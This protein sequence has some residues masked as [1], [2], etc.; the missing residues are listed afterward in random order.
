MTRSLIFASSHVGPCSFVLRC[1]THGDRLPDESSRLRHERKMAEK[2][3]RC[4]FARICEAG[5]V[6]IAEVTG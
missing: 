3:E 4:S 2:D 1:T 6:R 5:G